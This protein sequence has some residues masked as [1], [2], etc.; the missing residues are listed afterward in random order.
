[1]REFVLLNNIYQSNNRLP[2]TVTIPPGD[3]MGAIQIGDDQ[4][5]AAV[6]QLIDQVHVDLHKHTLA[7]VGRKAVTRNLSD[8]AAMAGQ[9]LCALATAALPRDFGSDRSDELFTA[10]RDTAASYGC[11]LIGGDVSI[12]DG[13]LHLTVTVLATPAGIDPVKR[14]GGKPGDVICVTGKLGKS[15]PTDH[16]LTF[17]PRLD[18]ARAIAQYPATRPHCMID[19]SDGLARDLGHLCEMSNVSAVIEQSK[20]PCRDNANWQ[21]AV[22]DGEDYE[23]LFATDHAAIGSPGTWEVMGVPITVIGRMVKSD[24]QPTVKIKLVDGN[25]VDLNDQGW[26][27]H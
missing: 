17:E 3:D 10:M 23:L 2:A 27:H 22:G 20:L 9:P 25:I 21:Q 16:H 11:P 7:Q 13:P 24:N 12:W 26:E 15:Y 4:V 19:I 1:M 18:I 14:S 6:D 8:I 5:L